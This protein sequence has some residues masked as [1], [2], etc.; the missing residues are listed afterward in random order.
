M[1]HSHNTMRNLS[2]IFFQPAND[3]SLTLNG[4][5]QKPNELAYITGKFKGKLSFRCGLCGN[6]YDVTITQFSPFLGLPWSS[7]IILDLF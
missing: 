5:E 3:R 4:L 6:S 2:D 1:S 7:S